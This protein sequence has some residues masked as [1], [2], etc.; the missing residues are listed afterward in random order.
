MKSFKTSA[1]GLL[2]IATLAA[3]S[4]QA[5]GATAAAD[6][7]SNYTNFG[8]FAASN[9]GTGFGAWTLTGSDNNSSHEGS[10]LNTAS[11]AISISTKAWGFYANNSTPTMVGER[12]FTGSLST[13]QVFQIDIESDGCNGGTGHAPPPGASS[14]NQ[15]GFELRSG[16]TSRF[17][18]YFVGGQQQCQFD[19]SASGSTIGTNIFPS[20]G[21]R[22]AFRL[23]TVDAYE[24]T[25]ISPNSG[26]AI[27]H[28]GT[29]TLGG[30][31][32]TGIDRVDLYVN[33]SSGDTYFNS[34]KIWY[35]APRI[36]A[37]PSSTTTVCSGNATPAMTVA[38]SSTDGS[39]LSY[40]WRRRGTGW[41][42]HSW[43][44]TDT[45]GN[46]GAGHYLGAP[47]NQNGQGTNIALLNG[48]TSWALWSYGSTAQAIAN[49]TLPAVL[50][51]N[52]SFSIDMQN[53]SISN[54]AKVG[55]ALTDTNGTNYVEFQFIGGQNDYTAHD[56][57]SAS[58]D[59]G[60]GYS[61]NGINFTFTLT[62]P[63]NYTVQVKRYADGE[64]AVSSGTLLSGGLGGIA[65][66]YMWNIH[67]GNDNDVFFN[68]IFVAGADDNGSNYGGTWAS[69]ATDTF[70]QKPLT[71]GPTGNGSFYVGSATTSFTIT[72]AQTADS[73]GYDCAV[74]S[75]QGYTTNSSASVLT[76]NASPSITSATPT[77]PTCNGGN[78]GQIAIVASGANTLNYSINGTTYQA[79]STLTGLT[80]GTYT[81][82]VKDT[83]N[84]CVT[85]QSGVVVGQPAA[86]SLSLSPTNPSTCG[87]A[88]GS[89]QATFSGGTGTL[90]V[91]IDSGSYAAQASPYT[92]T[93]LSAGLHTIYVQDANNCTTNR[94]STLVDPS[95]PSLGLSQTPTTCNGGSDG[96]IT[97]TFSGNG[98]FQ[99]NIDGGSYTPQTSPYTFTG[100]SAGSHTVT[101]KDVNG[102]TTP[103][104]I[105]VTQPA[106]LSLSLGQTATS[107]NGGSDG[108]VTATFSG[109]TGTLQVQIDGGSYSPQT[110]PY[111]FIGLSA[112]S[113]TVYLRDANGC[114]TSQSITVNQPTAL[115]CSVTPSGATVCAGSSQ[116][117]S[118][119][120]TGGTVGSGYTYSWTGPNSFSASA[121]AITINNAQPAN[122]GTYTCTVTDAN[123]CTS[124]CTATLTVNTAP[125]I[126]GQPTSESV[127]SNSTA[128]FTVGTSD[129]SASYFWRKRNTGWGSPWSFSPA[130]N[131]GN[132]GFFT[133]SSTN[134]GASQPT[135]PGND[136][137]IDSSGHIAFGLYANQNNTAIA[138]RSLNPSLA[139]GQTLKIDMDNGDEPGNSSVG[140]NLR[141]G[142]TDRFEVAFRGGSNDYVIVDSTG[143]SRDTGI[144]YTT[145]GLHIEFTLTGTDT[146]SVVFSEVG[147]D[148]P[149]NLPITIT[150]TLAG[151][152]GT[153]IDTLRL[154]NFETAG[155]PGDPTNPQR[156]AFFNNISYGCFDDNASNYGGSWT[157]GSD[158]GN[159]PLANG[160][161]I[162]GANT[163]TLTIS[164]VSSAD[165]GSY[166]VC[167]TNSCGI[168]GSTNVTLSLSAPPGISV[169]PQ[170]Q[171]V[172][173]P[174]GTTLSV[175]ASNVATYSWLENGSALS[176][177]GTIGGSAS[178]TLT[179]NATST[180]DSG[181]TF[182]VVLTSGSGCVLTSQVAT[183]TVLPGIQITQ[184]P[185]NQTV[186]AGSTVLFTAAA[187]G[188]G[189]T[190]QWNKNG[191]P[192]SNGGSVS[193][194]TTTSLTLS[195]VLAA[196][197]G[198]TFSVTVDGGT[199]CAPVTSAPATLTVNTAPAITNQPSSQAAC[200]GGGASFSVGATGSGLSYQWM[201]GASNLTDNATINGS[202]S[203]TLTLSGLTTADNSATFSVVVSGTCAPSATSTTVTLTVSSP[204]VITAQPSPQ[205]SCDGWNV[206]FTVTASNATTY[207]WRK[208]GTP[209]GNGGS[210]AGATTTTLTL[211]GVHVAD[212]GALFDVVV[213]GS[214][215]CA[216][217]NSTAV[218]L[219]VSA[220]P[221]ITNQPAASVTACSNSAASFSVGATGDSLSYQWRKRGTGWASGWAL[222]PT[223]NSS[224]A[225]FFVGSST[226]NDANG[227]GDT[228][229]DGDID[230]GTRSW[231]IYANSSFNATEAR[232]LSSTP[233]SVGQTVSIDVDNGDVGSGGLA[234]FTLRSGG[235]NSTNNVLEFFFNG[236]TGTYEINQSGG[237]TN[238]GVGITRQGN[239]VVVTLTSASTYSLTFTRLR[240]GAVFGPYTGSLIFAGNIDRIR[241]F[242]INPNAGG[243]T[244]DLLINS[245]TFGAN[246]DDASDSAY[247][248]GG[249]PNLL[250]GDNGGGS[251]VTGATSSSYTIDHVQ[252]GDVG[253]YDVLVGGTCRPS[254]TSSASVLSITA[255]PSV[256]IT[257]PAAVCGNSTNNSASVPDAGPG[258]TY[259]WSIGNGSITSGQSTSDILFS[260][261]ASGT[262]SLNISVT[263]GA[264]CT[265]TGST[266]VAINAQPACSI[267]GT[268][269]ICQGG[270]TVFCA[271]A[272]MASYSWGGPGGFSAST[273]CIAIGTAGLYSVTIT[274]SN[275][276]SSSCSQALTVNTPPTCNISG[277][278][279]ICQGGTT[280]F[281]ATVGMTSYSWTGPSA[282]T[283]NSQCVTVSV[284][285][286]YSVTITDSNGCLSS[287]SQTLTVNSLP[288]CSISGTSAIC[289]GGSTVFCATAG[290]ASYAWTGPSA[291][292]ANSDCVTASVAGLYSVTVTDSNGCSINC[293]QTLTVNPASATPTAGSN[294]PIHQGDT[295]NLTAATVS[296]VTY[297][298]TGP[299]SFAA[300]T[301]NPSITNAL[302]AASG[303]YTVTVT[304]TNGCTA[305]S[306]TT[307]LVSVLQITSITS[308]GGN[309]LITW[310]GDGGTT[311]QV[312][313]TPGKPS[314]DYANS[315]TDIG[316]QLLLP[317]AG[318][319]TTN[320]LDVGGATNAPS[321][322]YR[323]RLVP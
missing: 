86:L 110:S 233:L 72:N 189:L 125:P 273:Q 78:N 62:S 126:T 224:T 81:V 315:Y 100:L 166:D 38:A 188:P 123:G 191:S 40:A 290:M 156:D 178:A 47:N 133:G 77:Q 289:Q 209:L 14:A 302:A 149:T 30:S 211:T 122:A 64:T 203:P 8:P 287:C 141:N 187:N 83:V 121:A 253:S 43:T 31:A 160:G 244:T 264:G 132:T 316:S 54:G 275:G 51:V 177:G 70:G 281:C 1:C 74:M 278:S 162:S 218:T 161:H 317:G 26:Q 147:T 143:T 129:G 235:D 115:S 118:A 84:N 18:F 257:A 155:S 140:F 101:V 234:G 212:S 184:P 106:A 22:V 103:Q 175:T 268:N 320:Y 313:A 237:Y 48:T 172:C 271:T 284:T 251:N 79:G 267:T 120:G 181:S 102:C 19:D 128:T 174:T 276:C 88:N 202:A 217:T 69:G 94:A 159:A 322:Y 82:Y 80:A 301:Q 256:T 152:A 283:A 288:S 180:N 230:T 24:F 148:G 199:G 135:D 266:T 269:A 249:S 183:L 286:L 144:H 142:G 196:D 164:N 42:G 55:F 58:R 229:G 53:G 99:L 228:N 171:M 20:G 248:H 130:S 240:D 137:D 3:W 306:S 319:V 282:F 197:S 219:T 295:L 61:N 9:L 116:P 32:G 44:I 21:M 168:T 60:I 96:Q 2:T 280:V 200:I 41:G 205:T 158:K 76:V 136:G 274:D 114:T 293:S 119:S 73:A 255:A 270:S 323:I 296:D 139:V 12:P 154:F 146:Y 303:T 131:N 259:A 28:S 6:D 52:Q 39:T 185:T 210:V 57:S 262:V 127:C 250:N 85:T 190:Y 192:L 213:G 68:N 201:K 227:G 108:K 252:P 35:D 46:D 182:A 90:Q 220:L 312:Q 29:R 176:D 298:W 75:G 279:V 91:E 23:I 265:S 4:P 27:Y 104:L 258:A 309:I 89:I 173:A 311:N 206:S 97:A 105:T 33:N 214:A 243:P 124:Q 204:P 207:A 272:G 13:G 297:S 231:G 226:N 321:R 56:N 63:T 277:T 318:Q 299:N 7:A 67:A 232:R 95:G 242:L 151:T 112:G 208:N 307:V 238:T 215:P 98:P 145:Q 15:F 263:T 111:T 179:I 107:C 49:R 167:L 223:N 305:S 261:G 304:D 193:G 10:Y 308:Q 239:R 195:N 5:H 260:A 292:S 37:G 50:G 291:F 163:S 169:Q 87:G 170:S 310:I 300:S 254:V 117:F 66:L 34:M 247:S 294:S 236:S 65:K 153:A 25:V 216:S 246:S 36:T 11:K 165:L 157:N 45:G 93:G 17:R 221:V 314:G 92:F 285:G 109:G 138:V 16:S 225:G 113:H 71:D 59:L 222:T 241:P 245:I 198:A 134:N 150:G 194:A 186:C